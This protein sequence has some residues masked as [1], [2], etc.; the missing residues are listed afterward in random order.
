MWQQVL[1]FKLSA[2]DYF[3]FLNQNI[4]H[5]ETEDSVKDQLKNARGLI[6]YFLPLDKVE[7]SRE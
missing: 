1:D 2:Y 3:N 7:K 5:E 6:N 4:P